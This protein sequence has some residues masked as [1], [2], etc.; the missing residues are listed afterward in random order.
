MPLEA[1]SMHQKEAASPLEA[2]TLEVRTR[3]RAAFFGIV[4]RCE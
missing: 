2:P 1:P 4:A 3:M